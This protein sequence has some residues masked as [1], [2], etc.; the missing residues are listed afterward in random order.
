MAN[1]EIVAG[2]LVERTNTPA[3]IVENW[4]EKRPESDSITG[5]SILRAG[6]RFIVARWSE[7]AT[8]SG[9]GYKNYSGRSYAALN[10]AK[11]ITEARQM[12]RC[13]VENT[14]EGI[15]PARA[16]CQ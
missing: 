4:Q 12:F 13:L 3:E 5:V 1:F 7:L 9:G 6:K 2:M 11:N 16:N 15:R 10:H 8:L 14:E